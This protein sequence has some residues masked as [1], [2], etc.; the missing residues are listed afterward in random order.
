MFSLIKMTLNS[1]RKIVSSV[2][3]NI[4]FY[5][6]YRVV[7][8]PYNLRFS[9]IHNYVCFKRSF[10]GQCQLMSWWLCSRIIWIII[11]YFLCVAARGSVMVWPEMTLNDRDLRYPPQ[12]V[13][14]FGLLFALGSQ[15]LLLWRRFTASNVDTHLKQ[16]NTSIGWLVM[17]WFS[18]FRAQPKPNLNG[19]ESWLTIL[20]LKTENRILRRDC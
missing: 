14:S 7:S 18:V 13:W 2:R 16:K 19:H 11:V 4:V 3:I 20:A 12:S 9:M 5:D 8:S 10:W 1:V 17:N 15:F 6:K